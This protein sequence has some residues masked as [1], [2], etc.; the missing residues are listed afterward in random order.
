VHELGLD[1][2]RVGENGVDLVPGVDVVARDVE[3]LPDASRVAKQAD[4]ALGEVLGVRQR[5]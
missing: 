4:K 3:D 2:K 5:P 1:A